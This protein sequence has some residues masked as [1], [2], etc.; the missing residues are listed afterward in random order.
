MALKYKRILLKLSGEVLKGSSDS[1]HDETILA[2]V[3][4]PFD[5]REAIRLM[6][7]GTVALFAGDTGN[8]FFSTDSG[9]ALRAAEIGADALL[10]AT[11]VDGIYSADPATGRIA[12]SDGFE[13][14]YLVGSNLK[15][16]LTYPNGATASWDYEANRDLLTKVTNAH[17]DGTGISSYT[18]TNDLLGRRTSKNDEQYGYNIRDELTSGQ[19][20]TYVYDDIGN[21][22]TAEGK[23]YTANNL[24]QYTAIDDFTPQYDAD[25]NQ[26]LIKTETGIWSVTYNAENRPVCWTRGDT[27]VTMA[28]DRLGRRVD[29]KETRAGQVATHFRFVYDNFLCVQRLN[30]AN[31]NAVRTEFVWDPTEP[32]ATRPLVMRAKNWDLNLFYTHDGNKN[33]SEVFYHALQN[34]IAAHYDY[35]PFG[36][37]SRTSRATRVTN[38]DF[39]SENPFRFSSEYHDV[40]LGLVYYNYRHYNPQDGHWLS[41]DPLQELGGLN[42][43]AFL[44]NQLLTDYLGLSFWEG[45]TDFFRKAKEQAEAIG[46]FTEQQVEEAKD[47]IISTIHSAEE[48]V[49]VAL[50]YAKMVMDM[51]LEKMSELGSPCGSGP[52]AILIPDGLPALLL[53]VNIMVPNITAGVIWVDFSACCEKHDDCYVKNCKEAKR[54][55]EKRDSLKKACDTSFG[56][57][58]RSVYDKQTGLLNFQGDVI[59]GIYQE[60]VEFFGD[61]AFDR[62]CE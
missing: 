16:K 27:I 56:D 54:C 22:T 42:L 44:D 61:S 29:Y 53:D 14:E 20:Q 12:E 15:S 36:A 6:G 51:A 35:A 28:F 59:G 9:A 31:G 2:E 49:K 52:S 26:T 33:V 57:C 60:S 23:T 10:K 19:N 7:Q 32:I 43:Y 17:A 48:R 30:A 46:R 47:F 13:W 55:S 3:A 8:P 5:A 21:R 62:A 18:Y 1:C 25:G 34:G 39:L 58:M 45:V 37:V 50:A 4:Q 11:K 38:R 41:L 24:N 40:S